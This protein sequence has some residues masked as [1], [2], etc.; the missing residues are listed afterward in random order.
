MEAAR[1]DGHGADGHDGGHEEAEQQAA[2]G[3]GEKNVRQEQ[4]GNEGHDHGDDDVGQGDGEG[5]AA[6]SP[7]D[8]EV[9]FE[10]GVEQ[11]KEHAEPGDGFEHGLLEG[12]GREEGSVQ[13]RHEP[14]E[15]GG[16]Q[17]DA[18]EQFRSQRGLFPAPEQFPKAARAQQQHEE[19]RQKQENVLFIQI[20]H[21]GRKSLSCGK[22]KFRIPRA[23][24][25]RK[26]KYGRGNSTKRWHTPAF[27]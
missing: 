4:D 3:I 26:K 20:M 10:P 19:L 9:D 12:V 23:Q 8:G 15:Q 17:D 24:A 13:S 1:G 18:H 5:A 6:L 7:G 21:R 11:E 14:A 27:A 25:D 2:G 22:Y 16:A